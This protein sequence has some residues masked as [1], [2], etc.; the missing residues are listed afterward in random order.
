MAKTCEICGKSASVGHQV[1]ASD[2][3][4]KRKFNANLQRIR[5]KTPSGATKRAYVCTSC[6]KANKVQKA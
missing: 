1:S 3:K 2:K 4:N 5:I 6:I